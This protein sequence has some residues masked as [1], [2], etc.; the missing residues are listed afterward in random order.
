MGTTANRSYPYPAS[1]DDVRPYA[2]IQALADAIDADVAAQMA[3]WT[4]YTPTFGAAG[5]SPTIGAGTIAGR[6]KKIGRLVTASVYLLFGTGGNVGTGGFTISLP[7]A[8]ANITDMAWLGA[9]RLRDLSAGG[10][11][12]FVG[13]SEV[14]AGA[15]TMS[16]YGGTSGQQVTG[17]APFTWVAT[18]FLRASVT[19]EAAA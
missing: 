15:T 8:A 7:V 16:L 3:A 9:A 18:D 14:I 1:T 19:Y 10:N 2:D 17:T 11:G 5:G 4:S 6:Y 13:I 12:H